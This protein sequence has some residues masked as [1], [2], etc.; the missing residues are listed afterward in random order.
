M[1]ISRNTDGP[2]PSVLSISS[3]FLA[4][5]IV[6]VSGCSLSQAIKHWTEAVALKPDWAEVY[7][8]LAWVLAANE[9]AKLRDPEEA[10]QFAKKACELTNYKQPQMLDT[11]SVAYA[12]AGRF[13]QAIETAEK[14]IN[15]AQTTGKNELA[16]KI[17]KRLQLY[18]HGQP[19]YE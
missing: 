4:V 15:L 5:V 2:T 19:Y 18:Q 3:R 1:R 10:V 11:L 9:D 12:A 6:F 16:E 13:P 7:N 17:Q 14:A 8:N